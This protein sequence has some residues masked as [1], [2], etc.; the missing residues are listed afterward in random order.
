VQAAKS[1]WTLNITKSQPRDLTA[2]EY[3]MY[4]LRGRSLHSNVSEKYNLK[5]DSLN[6]PKEKIVDNNKKKSTKSDKPE[7]VSG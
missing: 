7:W 2:Y 6:H 3:N 4:L 1:T 5:E